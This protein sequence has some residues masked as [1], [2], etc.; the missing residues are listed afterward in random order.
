MILQKFILFILLTYYVLKTEAPNP[1]RKKN[2]TTL[3]MIY[4]QKQPQNYKD[5][6]NFK[7]ISAMNYNVPKPITLGKK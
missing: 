1:L 5:A 3:E 7:Q 4:E 2:F 6:V